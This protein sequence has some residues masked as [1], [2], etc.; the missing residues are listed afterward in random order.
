[1]AI[2]A[3]V[4]FS[5]KDMT[6]D[7][8]VIPIEKFSME[9]TFV[10]YLKKEYLRETKSSQPM[11]KLILLYNSNNESDS[12]P[13]AVELYPNDKKLSKFKF[14]DN[15]ELFSFYREDY[16]SPE[17][18][19]TK[20]SWT[21][22]GCKQTSLLWTDRPSYFTVTHQGYLELIDIT[23]DTRCI[24][25]FISRTYDFLQKH[26]IIFKFDP[27]SLIL[28]ALRVYGFADRERYRLQGITHDGELSSSTKYHL[29]GH[30]CKV[31]PEQV[32][33]FQ[34]EIRSGNSYAT[35]RESTRD[36]VDKIN[37]ICSSVKEL[38][39]KLAYDT[40]VCNQQ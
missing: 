2:E 6:G 10:S 11:E 7:I 33:R 32:S 19:Q 39:S 35:I 30:T 21:F 40:C 26:Y 12:E 4:T 34:L 1:M 3:V 36:E 24:T 37:N 25:K 16:L 27:H 9:L 23:T 31:I 13:T 5:I 38:E 18:L 28:Y 29:S 15:I 8:I 22:D 17:T 20:K 14:K